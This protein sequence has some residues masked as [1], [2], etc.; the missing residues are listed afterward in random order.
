MGFAILAQ[1]MSLVAD[2]AKFNNPGVRTIADT[3]KGISVLKVLTVYYS[4]IGVI[5]TLVLYIYI[6]IEIEST[7]TVSYLREKGKVA[8][9]SKI[10]KTYNYA[11]FSESILFI[12]LIIALLMACCLLNKEVKRS[13]LMESRESI[14]L[15]KSYEHQ[16][17]L[18]PDQ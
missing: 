12:V 18:T 14:S 9:I 1:V 13:E 4:I 3:N 8:W 6:C 16:P 2:L 15:M 17:A 10:L 7:Y 5:C 11:G